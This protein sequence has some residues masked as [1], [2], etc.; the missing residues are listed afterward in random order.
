MHAATFG[1]NPIAAR[2]GIAAIE[3]IEQENLLEQAK[4]IGEV[5]HRRMTALQQECELIRDVRVAGVMIGVELSVEGAP[6]VKAC[7]DR[8]MLINCTHGN[9]LR[10]LPAM[11]L[12]TAQAEEACDVLTEVLKEYAP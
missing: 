12:T 8:K 5:F 7:M 6:F 3:M 10:L 2:A 9:V 11:N 4:V 1:G